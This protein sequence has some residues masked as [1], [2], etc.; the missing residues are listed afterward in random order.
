MIQKMWNLLWNRGYMLSNTFFS[1]FA[2]F[3]EKIDLNISEEDK[4]VLLY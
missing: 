3:Y 4:S 2:V 1:V